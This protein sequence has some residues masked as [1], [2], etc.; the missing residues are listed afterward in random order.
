MRPEFALLCGMH[1]ENKYIPDDEKE[2][3]YIQTPA[4]HVQDLVR[5][6]AAMLER[7]WES[8]AKDEGVSKKATD[9]EKV[10]T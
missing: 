8:K 6:Y 3:W 7:L 4:Q 1:P 9:L 10:D 5:M 2:R